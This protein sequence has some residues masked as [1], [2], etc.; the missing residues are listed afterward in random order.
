MASIIKDAGDDP[1]VTNGAEIKAEARHQNTDKNTLSSDFCP[2]ASVLIKGGKGVGIVTRPGLPV[3][4]GETAINPVPRKM[5][6]EAVMEAIIQSTDNRKQNTD[7]TNLASDLCLL[8]SGLERGDCPSPP[9]ADTGTAVESGLSPTSAIEITISVVNGEELAKK[10]LN[11]RLG[12]IG[13]ISIL[14]TTGIVKPISSEAWTA[15]ITSS[16]DVAKAMGHD[17]IVL[18]AGRT[19]EKA[20]M[21]KYNLPEESYVGRLS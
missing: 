6:K 16:M 10:T 8:Y 5:I 9:R 14:G 12:I 18:S 3:S 20:H 11:S 7:K 19:S 17:E 1:D 4:V 21:K 13:G 15:T 2:L